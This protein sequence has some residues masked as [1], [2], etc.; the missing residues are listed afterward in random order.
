ME[1]MKKASILIV[2]DMEV[3]RQILS[4]ILKK[5]YNVLEASNG[6]EAL[7]VLEK[8]AQNVALIMLDI[9]MPVMD[10]FDFLKSIKAKENLKNI[11][12][13]FVTAETSK[14][15]ILK[16]IE[17]G[18]CDV[19][20]KPFD[21]EVVMHRVNQTIMLTESQM[22]KKRREDLHTKRR[23]E[24][25]QETILIV[26]DMELNRA[27]LKS[28]LDKDCRVLEASDGREALNILKTYQDEITVVLLDIVMPVMDGVQMMN[29]AYSRGLLEHTPVI[30]I[31][32]DNSLIKKHRLK[33]LGI[34][35]F[36]KK[37]FDPSVVNNRIRNMIN[38]YYG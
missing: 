9:V 11:P 17:E 37:P 29:E 35:E 26:D 25:C 19:I 22:R 28:A 32:A 5:D 21:P 10:G 6:L 15:N 27:L 34:C 30:A 7:A 3:N 23:G 20:A 8:E 14:S 38:L 24:R 2:E 31:T 16:G 4:L 1:N 13:I 33:E 18:V 12:I 36:I